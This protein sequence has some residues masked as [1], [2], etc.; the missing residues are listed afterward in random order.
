MATTQPAHPEALAALRELTGGPPP[1]D[2]EAWALEALGV[3]E[4]G[5]RAS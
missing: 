5:Q 1:A 3:G 4:A 2:A